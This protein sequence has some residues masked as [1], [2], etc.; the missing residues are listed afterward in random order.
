MARIPFATG[1]EAIDAGIRQRRGGELRPLDRM[2][3][4]SPPVALG[5]NELLGAIRE[6]TSFP[7]RLRELAILRIAVLNG[8]GYEWDAHEPVASHEGLAPLTIEKLKADDAASQLSGDESLV[9]RYTDQSTRTVRVDDDTFDALVMRFGAQATV[10]LAATVAAYNM[11]S[12]FLVATGVGD[13]VRQ[14]V[15]KNG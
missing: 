7:G 10:E 3:L 4:H 11:V 1:T 6:Q 5:W 2:L 12:R 15:Q 9:C 14:E 13:E 8:C